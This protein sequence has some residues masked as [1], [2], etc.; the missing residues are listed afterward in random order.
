VATVFSVSFALKRF[1]KDLNTEN[2]EKNEIA[3]KSKLSNGEDLI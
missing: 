1:G 2:A 3:E